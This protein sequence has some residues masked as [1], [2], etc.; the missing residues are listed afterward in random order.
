[1]G[2][3][4]PDNIERLLG[5]EKAEEPEKK[6]TTA[7]GKNIRRPNQVFVFEAAVECPGYPLYR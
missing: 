1:M 3:L 4:Y 7:P 6:D 2:E 5:G